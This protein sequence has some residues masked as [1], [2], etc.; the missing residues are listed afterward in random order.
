[1][2]G[3]DIIPG[4]I[5]PIPVAYGSSNIV[6]NK[7]MSEILYVTLVSPV[8]VAQSLRSNLPLAHMDRRDV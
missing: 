1:M 3:I 2:Y 7:E 8:H 6:S 4:Y 5:W